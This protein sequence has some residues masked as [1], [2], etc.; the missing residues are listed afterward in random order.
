MSGTTST[1]QTVQTYYQNILFRTGATSEV[2][3][4]VNGVTNQGLTLATVESDF[5]SSTE[6]QTYV[7]P[8][9]EMY[10][11]D[12][13]RAA[14]TAGLAGWVHLAETGVSMAT[15]NADIQA[16]AEGQAYIGGTTF[17]TTTATAFVTKLYANI[18]NRTPDSGSSGWITA[19]TSG[20][21]TAA[22]VEN[23]ILASTEAQKDMATATTNYL[24][25]I[26]SGLSVSGSLYSATGTPGTTYTLTAGG[27][28][29]LTGNNNVINGTYDG[30][31]TNLGSYGAGT[32]ITA[33]SGST[34]NTLNLADIGTG[35]SNDPN[36]VAG[37]S[38][39]GIQ[40][41]NIVSGKA[42]T[43]NMA[44]GLA[45]FSGLTALNIKDVG[46]TTA[47]AAGTTAVNVT[48]VAT[49]G[50]AEDVSGGAA[51]SVTTT[52][53]TSGG[54][55]NVGTNFLNAVVPAGAITVTVNTNSAN[56]I[57][58]PAITTKGGTTVSVTENLATTDTS[59]TV[60]TIGGAVNV[61][62][63][64]ATTSVSVT[65][66]PAAPASNVAPIVEGVQD[67]GV[68]ITD[69]GWL[70][71]KAGTITSVT[72]SS[73]G[74]AT[75]DDNALANLSLAGTGLGVT[76]NDNL[77]P[78]T[79]TTLALAISGL[80]DTVGLTDTN[81]EISTINVTTGGSSASKL[82]SITDTG[83]TTLAVSGTQQLVITSATGGAALSTVTVSGGAG[84]GVTLAA[85]TT[86]TSTST[87]TDVVTITAPATKAVTGNGTASEEIVWNSGTAPA[88][89]TSYL[90]SSVTGF[91][92]FG[93][94]ANV[95][96]AGNETFDMSKLTG[97]TG[98]LDVQA[99]INAATIQFIN[100]GAATPLSIDGGVNST[101]VY[102]TSDSNGPTDTVAVTLGGASTKAG[103]TVTGLT[104]EDSVLNGIG[105]V[106]ITS[107]AS[108][109]KAANVINTLTDASLTS[110]SVAGTGGLTIA[111][112]FTDAATSLTINGTSSGAAPI[113]FGG[114]ISDTKLATLT[115]TG[116]DGITLGTITDG[117]SGITVSGS[118]LNATASLT[119]TGNT[120]KGSTD[121]VTLGNGNKDTVI[122]N[123]VAVSGATVSITVGNGTGNVVTDTAA[124]AGATVNITAGTGSNTV[125]VAGLATNT[126]TFGSHTSG[127]ADAVVVGPNT[128]GS[129]VPSAAI[130]GLN[131][132][133]SDTI[134]FTGD[135][136]AGNGGFTVFTA[137]QINTFGNNPTTISGAVNGILTGAGAA[138]VALHG[139]GA[140][141]FQG[142]TYLVEQ[143]NTT[144]TAFA[145]GDTLVQLNGAYAFSGNAGTTTAAA[146]VIH[147]NG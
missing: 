25:Q 99:N 18:L 142:N 132:T 65:Q 48:D 38:V 43:T 15:I 26:G 121:S 128:S 127:T 79:A 46:G 7:V 95:G 97:F 145:A 55:V 131:L 20:T 96:S 71:N 51:V 92:V 125:T 44:S 68:T 2:Q 82:A 39:S 61:T 147:L 106:A 124:Q 23:A 110:L 103:F 116:T 91:K 69:A 93:V 78:A 141:Q 114:G 76:I 8:I 50:G 129:V 111:G 75:I 77:A 28:V 80:T 98:G 41:L 89:G 83:L 112:P 73:Y 3:G 107:N 54:Q 138:D 113:T 140:F 31:G 29:N 144:G 117:T 1:A 70:T 104:L 62:G 42:V 67:G 45:G 63:T 66:T 86:F 24:L 72:L 33:A 90:G 101:I 17:T 85:G 100:V 4:W 118:G 14:D 143:N 119:L 27:S 35:A 11:A 19:L 139:I 21:M 57:A 40:T 81:N 64:S 87:G 74:V 34:G 16:S 10:Q 13:G 122:D 22:Q 94:G 53:T 59:G 84:L 105:T 56:S 135:V 130:S 47:T 58:A 134:Q 108:T 102:Q 137:Q 32:T 136:T 133:G 146:G 126:I 6:A 60:T 123:G 88:A 52:S 9:V 36:A 12:L 30:L 5:V 109:S 49:N 115:L 120:S 37:A